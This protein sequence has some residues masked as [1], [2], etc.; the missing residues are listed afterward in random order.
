SFRPANGMQVV[1]RGRLSLFEG[2]GE[3]QMIVE[4]LEEAGEGLLRKAFEQLK[5]KLAEEGLFEEHL[6]KSLPVLPSHLGIITSP[7]GA[8]IRDVLQ[9]LKRRFPAIRIS[10]LPVQVQGE[11]SPDQI[12]SAIKAANTYKNDPI[13]LLLLTRGGGSLEDLWAFNTE[14][15][16]RAIHES[17]L[18]L[19]SAIGHETDFSI[20]DFVADLRAPTPSAAAEMLSPDQTEWLQTWQ[21]YK[22]ILIR[23]MHQRLKHASQETAHLS[24]RLR[25]PL[26]RL[27]EFQQRTDDYEMRLTRTIQ[28]QLSRLAMRLDLRRTQLPSP[29]RLLM[30]LGSRLTQIENR[31]NAFINAALNRNKQRLGLVAQGLNALNPLATLE[32]GYAIL[33]HGDS[34]TEVIKSTVEVKSGQQITARLKNGRIQARVTGTINDS[35]FP[36]GTKEDSSQ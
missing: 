17:R 20:S 12:V 29:D 34:S 19:I 35:E 1:A 24:K 25:S 22:L 14:Q 30:K 10:I 6:K 21:R 16:A 4:E 9:I 23:L 31:L 27:Q 18:P 7:T 32:R 33:T 13:D 2:R 11:D 8:A 28:Q 26:T 5:R 15:V 36:P 3:F